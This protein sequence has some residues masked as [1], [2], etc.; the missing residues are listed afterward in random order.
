MKNSTARLFFIFSLLAFFIASNLNAQVGTEF[1]FV[2]PEVTSDHGDTPVTFRITSFD[3]PATVTFSMPATGF[4]KTI[5]VPANSQVKYEGPTDQTFIDLIENRPANS[6]LDKGILITSDQ[7]ISVY[8]DVIT[9]NNN[10]DKFTLKGDNALGTEFFVPSQDGFDNHDFSNNP[11]RERVD[12]VATQDNTEITIIPSDDVIGHAKG[13][14]ITITLNRGQTYSVVATQA[15]ESY[16]RHLGGTS[17]SSSAPVAVTI[18]DDSIE[19]IDNPGHWDLIGDQLIP[20]DVIGTE[21]IAMNTTF[22]EGIKSDQKVYILATEDNTFVQ[23][24]NDPNKERTLSRG[25]LYSISIEGSNAAYI[26]SDKPVYAY[27]VTGVPLAAI[28][29]PPMEPNW[30][31]PFCQPF[32]VPAQPASRLPEF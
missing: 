26:T 24:N 15:G 16:S 7:D 8:Y 22:G 21:Y 10:P 28:A 23:V 18:S 4:S 13:E 12:I 25:E 31:V 1:W 29:R 11:A 2:A 6:V 27:Q 5:S 32:P 3:Q 14:T 9:N 20:T 17:I 19:R 30:E